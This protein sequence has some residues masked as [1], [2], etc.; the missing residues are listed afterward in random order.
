MELVLIEIDSAEWN[1]M[2]DWLANNPINQG[3]EDP[4]AALNDG[5]GW[6]Y[7]GS[8]KQ[9]DRLIHQFRHRKHPL[10]DSVISLSLTASK[11]MTPD[12]I[13]KKFKL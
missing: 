11:E 6:Q 10:N 2:W 12:Q 8:L 9:G 5:Q 4:S 3:I 1:Y 7:L 13:Q